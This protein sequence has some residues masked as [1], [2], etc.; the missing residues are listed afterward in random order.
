MSDAD[1]TGGVLRYPAAE[2]GPTVDVLHGTEVA[3]P[4]RWMETPSPALSDWVTAQNAVAE[5]YR[6]RSRR[7]RRSR[8]A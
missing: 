8:S 6:A 1:D 5:P 4:Y 2:R 7:A 3:D